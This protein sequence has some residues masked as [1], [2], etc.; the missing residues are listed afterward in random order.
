MIASAATPMLSYVGFQQ[1]FSLEMRL[2]EALSYK[3]GKK[4]KEDNGG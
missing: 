1:R 4:A 3:N 2:S